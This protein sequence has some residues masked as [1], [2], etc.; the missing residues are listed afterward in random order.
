VRLPHS[1]VKP[2]G[3]GDPSLRSFVRRFWSISTATARTGLRPKSTPLTTASTRFSPTSQNRG[4]THT[5][6]HVTK[7][8]ETVEKVRALVRRLTDHYDVSCTD[9]ELERVIVDICGG[10]PR[11]KR[12]YREELQR[13]GHIF[14]HPVSDAPVWYLDRDAWLDL[15]VDISD[16][17][18]RMNPDFFDPYPD[19]VESD[20]ET[21][22]ADAGYLEVDADG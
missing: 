18:T 1:N 7:G 6:D 21:A 17:D 12:K 22:L 14:E 16:A 19:T 13:R 3:R 2:V 8:S 20:Y 11:T 9:D 5:S 15:L 4:H 10:D